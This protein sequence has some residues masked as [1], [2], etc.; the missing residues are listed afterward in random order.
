MCDAG[1]DT[2][3]FGVCRQAIG[4]LHRYKGKRGGMCV[5]VSSLDW[6][7]E[8]HRL[9]WSKGNGYDVVQRMLTLGPREHFFSVI[10]GQVLTYL[11]VSFLVC[12]REK[13]T[14]SCLAHCQTE[15]KQ[16]V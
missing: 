12:N 6:E 5:T 13:G 1:Q 11:Y 4:I 9:V 16:W 7:D 2:S 15:I 8:R 10:V 3:F 14:F